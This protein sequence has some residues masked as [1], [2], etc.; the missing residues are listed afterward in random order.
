MARARGETFCEFMKRIFPS[1]HLIPDQATDTVKDGV[2]VC[3]EHLAQ[4]RTHL[5]H[6]G[7]CVLT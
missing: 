7:Q 1:L 5:P 6:K 3:H 2:R 4:M